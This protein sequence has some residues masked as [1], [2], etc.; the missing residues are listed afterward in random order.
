MFK[1][2]A[3]TDPLVLIHVIFLHCA[4]E[5]QVLSILFNIAQRTQ[6][7]HSYALS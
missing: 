3:H 1:M 4:V 5:H 7:F 6:S 2:S